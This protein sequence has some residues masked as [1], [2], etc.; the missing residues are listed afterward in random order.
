MPGGE[1]R[2]AELRVAEAAP[3]H[4][5]WSLGGDWTTRGLAAVERQV[6]P[7]AVG[8]GRITLDATGVGAL[9]TAGALLL[10]RL[11]EGLGRAGVAVDIQGVAPRQAE[12]L[13]LVR[14]RAVPPEVRPVPPGR[15]GLDTLGRLAVGRLAEA[16]ALLGFIGETT[17]A[18][19]RTVGRPARLR[20]RPFL[21]T[22]ESAGVDALPIV[23]L[24]AFLIGVVIAYQ[25]GV[26]LRY[27]GANIY[28]V[29]LVS[30]T[31]V[32]ELAPMMTAII[33]AGRT[34]SAFTA[35][36]GTMT[37]TEEVDALRTIGIDPVDLLV[38]PKLLGLLVALPLLTLVADALGI[39]GGM[40][41]AS[42]MLGVTFHD[43]LDRIPQAVSL[44]SVM[45]GIGKA[46]VFAGIIA[47]VGCFQG[48]R[49]RGGADSVG[50]QT[51]VSVVQA[52]FLI[53]VADAAFSVLF[54]W[55][56]I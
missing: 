40:V 30:L 31:L 15:G 37:V 43:F 5:V 44:T 53:I 8:T 47:G 49:V 11:M 17:V 36:I 9:D 12:V 18:F 6:S 33:A 14:A 51:T 55:L 28:V 25:G 34:G 41:M 42:A 38:L 52:I 10:H 22:V 23:S 16:W 46:P 19:L 54:S 26:Q 48:F 4:V 32:R 3:G 21:A 39:L 7:P 45:I 29:E 35:Q 1:P 24:L 56:G 27:Y 2:A 20:W 50:R 13:A